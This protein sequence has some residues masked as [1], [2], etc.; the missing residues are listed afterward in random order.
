MTLYDAI[1]AVLTKVGE[2]L[3]YGEITERILAQG[4]WSTSGQTPTASVIAVLSME[5]K[6]HGVAAAFVRTAPGTYTLRTGATGAGSKPVASVVKDK[7]EKLAAEQLSFNDAA[8]LILEQYSNGKP[9]NYRTITEK[10]L[11][12]GLIQTKG[13]TPSATM[14]AQLTTEIAKATKR[15]ELPRFV[16]HG[17]GLY[18]LTNWQPKGIACEIEAHNETIRQQMRETLTTMKPG[19]FEELVS[20]LMI[21]L[22]FEDV[23]TTKIS[24]DGG[25]DVRGVLI[26]CGGLIRTQYA[27]QVKRWKANVQSPE[28]NSLRGCLAADE[29]GL[30]VTLSDYSPGARAEAVAIGKKP[31]TLITGKQLLGLLIEHNFGVR[32][33]E[34][35]VLEI[36]E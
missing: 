1:I 19:E 18:G 24:G 23:V 31:I 29:H 2:P 33:T 8:A 20:V 36:G 13:L 7:A 6:L 28:I 15:G 34:F 3:H 25:I 5:I 16:A 14:S 10:A 11:A 12:L 22:D 35:R 4:L 30:F 9:M 21:A 17:H 32:S 27:V 26:A